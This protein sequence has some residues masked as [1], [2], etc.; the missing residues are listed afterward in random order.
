MMSGDDKCPVCGWPAVELY[1]GSSSLTVFKKGNWY[2]RSCYEQQ[3]KAEEKKPIDI[4]DELQEKMEKKAMQRNALN[5][6]MDK[7]RQWLINAEAR[8][9]KMEADYHALA[10]ELHDVIQGK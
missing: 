7:M 2:H 10:R 1:G 6:K 8:R 5:K 4:V 3:Q 9:N